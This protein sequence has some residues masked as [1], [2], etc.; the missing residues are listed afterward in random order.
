M[1][2]HTFQAMDPIQVEEMTDRETN[3]LEMT[4]EDGMNAKIVAIHLTENG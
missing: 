1:W 3:D 4:E 2:T